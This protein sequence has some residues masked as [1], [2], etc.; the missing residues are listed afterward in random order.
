[1][2]DRRV[3]LAAHARPE[4]LGLAEP[5]REL[6][7]HPLHQLATAYLEQ[8]G[9]AARDD[10]EVLPPLGSAAGERAAVEDPVRIRAEQRGERLLEQR[11][12]E[13]EVDAYDRRV[14]ELRFRFPEQARALARRYCDDDRFGIELVDRRDP[15][16]AMHRRAGGL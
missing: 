6:P 14:V 5:L 10:R 16:L 8:L 7:G 1:Q 9:H 13:P 12:G 3:G 11:P 15:H 4:Q 2:R